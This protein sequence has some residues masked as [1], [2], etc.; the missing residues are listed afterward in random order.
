MRWWLQGK[1]GMGKRRE[2]DVAADWKGTKKVFDELENSEPCPAD[3]SDKEPEAD[4]ECCGDQGVKAI[5][6]TSNH[7]SSFILAPVPADRCL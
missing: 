4:A 3:S 1:T 2:R 7:M 6:S 5:P